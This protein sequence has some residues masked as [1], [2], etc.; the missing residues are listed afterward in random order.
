MGLHV[1]AT[2]TPISLLDLSFILSSFQIKSLPT[3]PFLHFSMEHTLLQ[4]LLRVPGAGQVG[5]QGGRTDS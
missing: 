3:S 2:V 4:R 5:T 1:C